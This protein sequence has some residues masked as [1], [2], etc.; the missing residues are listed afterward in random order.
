MLDHSF[1][2]YITFFGLVVSCVY[3][4]GDYTFPLAMDTEIMYTYH[5]EQGEICVT[6]LY[7]RKVLLNSTYYE[8]AKVRVAAALKGNPSTFEEL[9][10]KCQGLYPTQVKK[11]IDNMGI[12]DTLIPLYITD[13][14]L[15]PYERLDDSYCDER[16][17]ITASLQNN[18]ILSSWYFS[19]DTCYKIAQLDVWKNKRIMF[20]GTPRLFEY[21]ASRRFGEELV[22]VDLDGTVIDALSKKYTSLLDKNHKTLFYKADINSFNVPAFLENHPGEYDYIF[23]DPPW[24]PSYYMNWINIALQVL[25]SNG[26]ILFSLFPRL[27]RPTAQTERREIMEKCRSIAE[28]AFICSGILEYDIPSFEKKELENEGLILRS[29]WKTSDLVILNGI[30]NRNFSDASTIHETYSV[31]LEFAWLG[32]RWFLDTSRSFPS[33]H[34]LISSPEQTLYLKNPSKRNVQLHEVNLLS[35]KGHGIRI[36][37]PTYFRSILNKLQDLD[38][39]PSYSDLDNIP[40]DEASKTIIAKIKDDKQ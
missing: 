32:C 3:H 30:T 33:V 34:Q 2:T 10:K 1:C 39:F 14:N 28:K 4:D 19:W 29:N 18:P 26:T 11:I 21:F 38:Q 12:Y 25:S 7:W 23:L 37:D 15:L 17:I 27:L 35:S 22:L 16:E 6:L 31:W 9:C 40:I 5:Q 8:S 24:Y 20:L 13:Q 36:S